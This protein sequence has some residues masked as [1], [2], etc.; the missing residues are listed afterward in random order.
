[1][2]VLGFELVTHGS[3]VICAVDC[4]VDPGS[5][6]IDYDLSKKIYKLTTKSRNT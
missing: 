3:L 4:T 2:A 5:K 6:N 1:M